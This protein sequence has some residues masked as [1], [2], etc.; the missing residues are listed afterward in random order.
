MNADIE[1]LSAIWKD[2]QGEKSTST[3]GL[4][5]LKTGLSRLNP[6]PFAHKQVYNLY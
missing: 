3:E 2:L 6:D 5:N 1:K 4:L